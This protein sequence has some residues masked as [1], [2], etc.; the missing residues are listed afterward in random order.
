MEIFGR[1]I[2]S[3][4]LLFCEK[5][6]KEIGTLLKVVLKLWKSNFFVSHL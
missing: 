6:R 2:F 5:K 3:F 4:L 1:N